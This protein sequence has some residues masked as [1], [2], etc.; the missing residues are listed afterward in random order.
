M[1]CHIFICIMHWCVCNF[2]HMFSIPSS[3]YH[4]T[5]QHLQVLNDI[6]LCSFFMWST[7][8]HGTIIIWLKINRISYMVFQWAM[9]LA[10]M[11]RWSDCTGAEYSNLNFSKCWT[12]NLKFVGRMLKIRVWWI[13]TVTVI[14][15]C[16]IFIKRAEP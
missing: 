7:T 6:N 14:G 4:T 10:S 2:N 12:I 15:A 13:N 16:H 3:A 8:I 9:D 5:T 1:R 11:M